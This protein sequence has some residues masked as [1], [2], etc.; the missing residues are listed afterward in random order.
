MPKADVI[1][2]GRSGLAAAR[3]LRKEGWDV[4]LSDAASPERIAVRYTPEDWQHQQQQLARDGINLKLG[5]S[6]TLD[7]SDLP[8]LIVVSPG[9]PWDIPVLVAARTQGIETIGE[10]ELAWRYLQSCP[11]VGV[12]GTNGKTTTTS[13][14]AA[15]FQEAG[16]HAPACGNIGYAA[17][18]LL[19]APE[20][21]GK[22]QETSPIDWVIGEISSYQIES[23][24]DLAPRIGVLT[25]LTP[26]HLSR[27]KTLENYYDI[28]ASL[29]RRSQLQVIN[30]DDPYLGNLGVN[31]WPDAYWISI[32]AGQGDRNFKP[33]AYIQDDWVIADSEPILPVKSLQMVGDHNRQNLLM[34]VATARLAGIDKNAIASAI[35]KFPGVPH[36]LEKVITWQGIDFINDSKATNYDAAQVGLASVAAPTILIAG[37]EAKAG[38]DTSWIET[39]KLKAAVVLLIGEAA[40]AF[41]A[42]LKEA[43]YSSY[44]IVETMAKAVP[45]AAELAQQYN[46]SV[47]LLSPACASFDQYQSFEHRG[48]DFRRLCQQHLTTIA[49]GT[50]NREQGTGTHP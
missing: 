50:G 21:T 15:I 18:E 47:V 16:F 29:L 46:S 31:Y 4:T 45:R 26:D 12:T 44:E 13:L 3:L 43:S 27:H 39:I 28:K 49:K 24:K 36:R 48:D 30:G 8:Q 42:R 25:T 1:G 2:L 20:I 23:S 33:W 32:T 41:A 35:A 38:D 40:P 37:G 19:L 6:L 14:I 34:A 9:V 7:S 11:W 10:I 5:Y 17:C 22:P